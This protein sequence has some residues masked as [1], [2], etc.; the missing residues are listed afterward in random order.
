MAWV[1]STQKVDDRMRFCGSVQVMLGC[2]TGFLD[3][4]LFVYYIGAGT[5]KR[6][7]QNQLA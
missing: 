7:V 1:S 6:T 4:S 5:D 2:A 3:D